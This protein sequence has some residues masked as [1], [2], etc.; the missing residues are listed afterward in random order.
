M[1]G[2][3]YNFD[4]SKSIEILGIEYGDP[5]V[6]ILEAAQTM[7]KVGVIEDK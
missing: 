1:W 3:E 7:I 4:S 2:K 5:N 6:S